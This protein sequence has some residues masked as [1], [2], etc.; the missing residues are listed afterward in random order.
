MSYRE[1]PIA[2]G[3]ASGTALSSFAFLHI[4]DIFTS[5]ILAIIGALISFLMSC[6]LNLFLKP[7]LRKFKNKRKINKK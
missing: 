2:I 1:F 6:I 4:E 5:A 7:S 3:T